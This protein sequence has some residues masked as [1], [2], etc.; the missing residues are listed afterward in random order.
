VDPHLAAHFP[1]STVLLTLQ[2]WLRQWGEDGRVYFKRWFDPDVLKHIDIVVFSEEDIQ[3]APELE[4]QF[5]GA[6]PHLFVTR[7]EK[8]GT[9]YRNGAPFSYET[10]Q[11]R[12]VNSTGAG[13]VFAASILAS[14]RLVKGDM[15]A[16][17]KVA[18]YLGANAITRPWLEGAPSPDEVQAALAQ[19]INS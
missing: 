14:L 15:L 18:A 2:G 11:V 13:D 6:V 16:A 7:A 3:E 10:P 4:Q 12:E 5:A 8:G 19:V 9:Y 1:D 17:V